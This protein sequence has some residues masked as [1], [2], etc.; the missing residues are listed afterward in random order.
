MHRLAMLFAEVGKTKPFSPNII[1]VLMASSNA[2]SLQ[3]VL[4]SV[5]LFTAAAAE[6]EL[7]WSTKNDNRMKNNGKMA[8]KNETV[9]FDATG[10]FNLEKCIILLT[11]CSF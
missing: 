4:L 10:S 1:S 7:N 6:A 3:V 9:D 11:L 5:L 2:L 8:E